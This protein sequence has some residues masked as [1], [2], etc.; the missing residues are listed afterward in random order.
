M[1]IN[2]TGTVRFGTSGVDNFSGGSWN[3]VFH[4]TADDYVTDTINGGA[5]TDTVDYSASAVGVKITLT[6]APIKGGLPTGGT[7]EADFFKGI[8]YD[9]ATHTY[10]FNYHHQVVANLTS[11]ENATGSD[12]ADTLIGNSANNVLKGN[13]GA[14]VIKAGGGDDTIHAGLGA[15]V[16]WGEAGKDT[17][18][19]TSYQDSGM[20][21]V[22]LSGGG[23]NTIN[24]GTDV[25]MDFVTGV[26]KIDLSQIDANTT[27]S[28]NQAFNIVD[29]FTG[30]AG[31]LRV[32]LGTDVDTQNP[33]NEAWFLVQGD[34]NGDGNPDLQLFAYVNDIGIVN[35][36]TD[37]IL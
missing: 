21:T 8:F 4:M 34:V 15:D 10:K 3:D 9:F 11:I 26:D 1:A 6:D 7:V 2:V 23:Y 22:P 30:H 5:G 29:E 16:L 25:I 28:G 24:H 36:T 27:Q 32:F 37:L 18:V 19:F 17:F 14:D 20:T 31:E 33:T 35:T 12:L 13:A